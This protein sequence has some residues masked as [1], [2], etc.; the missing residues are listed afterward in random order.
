[1]Y[2]EVVSAFLETQGRAD[3]FEL[4]GRIWTCFS[5]DNFGSRSMRR[6]LRISQATLIS[7]IR[8]MPLPLL[9]FKLKV[10]DLVLGGNFSPKTF[11]HHVVASVLH[12]HFP[13]ASSD[14]FPAC[15]STFHMY[16]YRRFRN[17]VTHFCEL[18]PKRPQYPMDFLMI[19]V[20][21]TNARPASAATLGVTPNGKLS[22]LFFGAQA[23]R[24]AILFL[25]VNASRGGEVST[26]RNESQKLD[27]H[28]TRALLKVARFNN[29]GLSTD[30]VNFEY[31]H[32]AT[33][34]RNLPFF[35]TFLKNIIFSHRSILLFS[36]RST[37]NIGVVSPSFAHF[38]FY[39]DRS[40][41]IVCNFAF[42]CFFRLLAVGIPDRHDPIFVRPFQG[43]LQTISYYVLSTTL[44]KL[45]RQLGWF[46]ITTHM[47]KKGLIAAFLI[48]TYDFLEVGC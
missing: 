8:F 33:T 35:L 9:E 2:V 15:L 11:F 20:L 6:R 25:F 14:H 23:F 22:P 13:G 7:Q 45:A 12:T 34:V 47:F 36:M 43:K 1:M 16:L 46:P 19:W 24:T 29:F 10:I 26:R 4:W 38:H 32:T 40:M 28:Q 27:V 3:L 30:G 5:L 44:K 41:C 42:L 18:K 39:E 37:K 21:L 31:I 48:F 17:G